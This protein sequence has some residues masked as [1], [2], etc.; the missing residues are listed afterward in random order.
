MWAEDDDDIHFPFEC[1]MPI[2]SE[3]LQSIKELLRVSATAPM[4]D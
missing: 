2:D 1:N 4:R 3:V